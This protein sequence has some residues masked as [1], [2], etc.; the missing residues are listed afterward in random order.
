MLPNLLKDKTLL[1]MK[2]NSL[3]TLPLAAAIAIGLVS[4]NPLKKMEKNAEIIEFTATPDPIEMHGD[5]V[6]VIVNG[7][8]PTK[9][10]HKLAQVV[11]T[12][13][14]KKDSVTVKE[15]DS[16]QF[17]G[18]RLEEEG[19]DKIKFME[20]G[21]F[22]FTTKLPYE[23]AMQKGKL[24]AKLDA[25]YKAKQQSLGEI[26][27]A[28]GTVTT[29]AL[30]MSDDRPIIG[31]DN[32]ERITTENLKAT[33]NY[34]INSSQVRSTETRDEDMTQLAEDIKMRAAD[35][36]YM[37][38]KLA[39]MGYASPDG[40]ISLN[41]NLANDR[42]ASAGKAVER[43][44]SRNK[45]ET[46]KE[47]LAAY[48]GA[49][50]DWAGFKREM[51]NSDI[52]DKELILR[53]LEM[54]TDNAKREQEIK[55]LAATYVEVADKILPKLRRAEITLT[56]DKVGRTD[57]Q[58]AEL[59][60]N[61]P[62]QLNVEEILYAA[63]LTNDMNQKLDIYQKAAQHFPEDWRTHNNVGYLYLLQN[64]LAEA[65]TQFN[66]ANS[67]ENTPVVNNNLGVIARLNGDR[68]MAAEYYD[69]A[70][71]AGKDVNYNKGIVNIK[72]G[73]YEDAVSNLSGF[74]S[75]NTALAQYLN[76]DADAAMST[77]ENSEE[78]KTA[79]GYYLKAVIGAS[80]DNK[81]LVMSNLKT[82][83][84]KDASM[85][86]QAMNDVS[87]SKYDLSSL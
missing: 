45:A 24:F 70:N 52:E 7:T 54:Y 48:E 63:T 31:A 83:V 55:N 33:I 79:E 13:V 38:K 62:A 17:Q 30:V 67:V 56:V 58:I 35:S 85:K 12:P 18:E 61:D 78:G 49:G 11:V 4:C 37:F 60:A 44:L 32:F 36:T 15:F 81:E 59:A 26:F 43:I 42:A 76:G 29:S 57:E 21:K 20:G 3:K 69:K 23:E 34:L 77:L 66:K 82:A 51:Q 16:M 80:Q 64:K 71:G 47:D 39:V 72:D 5:S 22:E 53:V 50:E 87:F 14:F 86:Q 75:F 8:F 10:F 28:E 68:A 2:I 41:D 40:E 9:Y 6:E 19:Y 25:T 73:D 84:S 46:E 74:D 1:E 65:E 27:I